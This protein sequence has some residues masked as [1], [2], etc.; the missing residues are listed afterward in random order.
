MSPVDH[1]LTRLLPTPIRTRASRLSCLV[2][3]LILGTSACASSATTPEIP[4]LPDQVTVVPFQLDAFDHI[5]VNAAVD[6][7]QGTFILDTGS[8]LILLNPQYLQPNGNGSVDTA[9]TSDGLALGLG[10]TFVTV[11]TVRLGTLLQP[12]AATSRATP[13]STRPT[14]W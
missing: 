12:L 9:P 7:H 11:H 14:A 8:P 10:R 6:G 5:V 1:S 2:G 13:C 3:V 4:T